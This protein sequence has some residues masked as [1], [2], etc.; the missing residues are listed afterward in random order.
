MK[1]MIHVNMMTENP[2]ST[3]CLDVFVE[4]QNL[5]EYVLQTNFHEYKYLT[6][7]SIEIWE[8]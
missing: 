5:K 6:F 2:I 3:K 8:P 4:E 1:K 7:T